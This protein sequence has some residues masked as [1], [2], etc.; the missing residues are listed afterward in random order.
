MK[1]VKHLLIVICSLA[2]GY[3]AF[4]LFN[5]K[6]LAED[7]I[8]PAEAEISGQK[9]AT[10]EKKEPEKSEPANTGAAVTGPAVSAAETPALDTQEPELLAESNKETATGDLKNNRRNFREFPGSPGLRQELRKDYS[11]YILKTKE[12]L[13]ISP[14]DPRL[15]LIRGTYQGIYDGYDVELTI[16]REE[17]SLAF[18]HGNTTN[19]EF[20]FRDTTDRFLK[21]V[22][23]DGNQLLIEKG[24]AKLVLDIRNFPALKASIGKNGIFFLRRSELP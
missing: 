8:A 5:E 11:Y 21:N 17:S 19:H 20:T 24:K 22:N 10:A 9:M 13:G 2:L 18:T 3:Y 1:K 14:E 4:P 12:S 7:E 6:R 15:G 23:T 16:G